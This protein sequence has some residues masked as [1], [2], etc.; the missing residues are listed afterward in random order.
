MS[1]ECD[2][3]FSEDD[4]LS[5]GYGW[6]IDPYTSGLDDTPQFKTCKEAVHWAQVQGYKIVDVLNG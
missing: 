3:V 4:D 2:I 5:S 6:Y 1:N